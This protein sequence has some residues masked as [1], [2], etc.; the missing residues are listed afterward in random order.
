MDS[1][2]FDTLN[3]GKD[4]SR[5][6]DYVKP[7]LFSVFPL[8]C[9]ESPF[10]I[11]WSIGLFPLWIYAE[12]FPLSSG[13]ALDRNLHS[14]TI[15]HN[16]G[17]GALAVE[18]QP[19]ELRQCAFVCESSA[20]NCIETTSYQPVLKGLCCTYDTQNCRRHVEV[21]ILQLLERR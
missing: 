18:P 10:I 17:Q 5:F 8:S 13:S 7:C 3:F 21:P 6:Q 19:L 2:A 1:S 9:Q 4:R 16:V 12:L 15:M 20:V 11:T 14:I